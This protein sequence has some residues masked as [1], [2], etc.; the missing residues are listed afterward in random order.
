MA[1]ICLPN[2][3]SSHFPVNC[4]LPLCSPRPLFLFS[5]FGTALKPQL[6]VKGEPLILW[7]SHRYIIKV[8]FLL[9]TFYVK[10]II[11]SAKKFGKRKKSI[12]PLQF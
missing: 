11:R 6:P 3:C 5:Y 4:L 8:L 12:S 2:I 1:N 10:L 7:C 9:L